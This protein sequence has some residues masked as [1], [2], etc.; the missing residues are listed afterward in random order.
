MTKSKARNTRRPVPQA[1][2]RLLPA[3]LLD[4]PLAALD[5]DAALATAFAARSL[6]TVG[7]L[8]ALST[9]A[10]GRS[11]WL[12]DDQAT[13]IRAA[14]AKLVHVGQPGPDEAAVVDPRTLREQLHAA[15]TEE[16]RNLLDLS[17]GF[18]GTTLPR[19]AIAA[20]L[21]TSLQK[22]EDGVRQV[23]ARLHERLP[24][25]LGRLR[26]ELGRELQAFDGV[27]DPHHAAPES[28]LH[29]LVHESNDPLLGARLATFCF[30]R[31]FHLHHGLLCNLSPRR[32]RRVLRTLPRIVRP[33]RLPL[34]VDAVRSE[35]AAEQLDVP[36]GL[37][38][39][40]LR[41]DLRVAVEQ[42]PTAGEMVVPD[43]RSAQKRLVDLLLEAGKPMQL[44]DLVFAYR[45]RFRRASRGKVEQRLR[46]SPLFVMLGPETWSLRDRH[47]KELLAVSP[48]AERMARRICSIGGRVNVGM[49]LAEEKPDDRTIW[50]V[51]DRLGVDPRVRLLGRG[52]ACPATHRQSQVLERLLADFR[53]AGGDVVMSM[54]VGN[55]PPHLHRL[56]GRLLRWNRL[57]VMP[58]DDRIDLLTNYPFDEARLRR[59]VTIVDQQLLARSGY[60]SISLLK[61][62]IDSTD[63]GGSWLTTSLLADL[64]RRHG[65]FEMLPGDLV[66]RRELALGSFVMRMLRQALREIGGQ[67]TVDDILQQR[68]DLAEFANCLRDLLATDPL[69]QSP[70]GERFSL[71]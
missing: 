66:A 6:Q 37:L 27:L 28:L 39:H 33:Q 3:T 57:F 23:R 31:D 71:V 52:D 12:A 59:L 53:R 47:A 60:A 14:I 58:A 2:N 67:L 49:L 13:A 17:V 62:A 70:D 22:L 35:L 24:A 7:D 20:R 34:A 68:P 45:E 41:K 54:F 10:F 29:T 4:V 8:L 18:D 43:P 40:L 63:L 56:I 19:T 65:P 11:G 38:L 48:L 69:V 15:L 36:R 32:F 16:E 25:L 5:L 51:L 9:R 21:R 44:D 26:Y 1:A 46:G 42:D 64:L 30:P 55:Q 50:L 61:A